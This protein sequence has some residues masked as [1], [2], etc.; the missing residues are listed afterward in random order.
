M[1]Q[2][3][4]LGHNGGHCVDPS[5]DHPPVQRSEWWDEGWIRVPGRGPEASGL[6]KMDIYLHPLTM[7]M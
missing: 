4:H 7:F 5:A 3:S 2:G 1:E 6:N